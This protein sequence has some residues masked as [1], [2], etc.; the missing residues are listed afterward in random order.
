VHTRSLR[1]AVSVQEHENFQSFCASD[2]AAI[3]GRLVYPEMLYDEIHEC[4]R[5]HHEKSN[6]TMSRLTS[7]SITKQAFDDYYYECASEAPDS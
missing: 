1:S 5:R 2:D 3:R 6:P 7:P 4:A